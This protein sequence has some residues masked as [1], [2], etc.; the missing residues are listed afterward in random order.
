MQ[1]M[2]GSMMIRSKTTGR[3]LRSLRLFFSL[4]AFVMALAGTAKADNYNFILPD[5]AE[6]IM[7]PNPPSASAT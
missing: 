5:S 7:F 1:K 6:K 2:G 4:C 3:V